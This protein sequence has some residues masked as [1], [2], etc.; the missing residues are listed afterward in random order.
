MADIFGTTPDGHDVIRCRISGGGAV[1][2]VL[3]WGAAVQ[4]F[5]ALG[6]DRSLVLGGLDMA[7]YLGPMRYF[8]AIVGPVANRIAGGQMQVAGAVHTLDKNEAKRT[9]LHGGVA[10][11]SDRNWTFTAMSP[12][13]CTLTLAHPD[14]L[15][16]FPGNMSVSVTYRLDQQGALVVIISG[17]T[18]APT[19]FSPAFHGYWNLSGQRD[20]GDHLLT[21][22]AETYLPV[23]HDQI[24]LG[25]PH[26]VAGTAFDYRMARSIG[27]DLDHNFCLSA[28]RERMQPACSLAAAGLVLDVTTDQPGVQIYN[29]RHINTQGMAG[30]GGIPYGACAGLAIE[31]QFWPDTPHQPDYPSSLL[32]PGQTARHRARFHVRHAS[33]A[34]SRD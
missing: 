6:Q 31:P 17:Q 7:A 20:L 23:D 34:L 4:D 24:P 16:G 9:T 11:F 30:H 5:H 25:P 26:P 18:D 13:E 12:S 19:Y 1:A 28:P 22:P 3:S 29:G 14:G 8:G 10:G 33:Q 27:V 21:I 32:L 2:Q 15:G